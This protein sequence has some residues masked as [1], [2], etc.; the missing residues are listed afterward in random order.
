MKLHSPVTPLEPLD[1]PIKTNNL[2]KCIQILCQGSQVWVCN[3]I[4]GRDAQLY[5]FY[6]FGFNVL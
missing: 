4:C 6:G 5:I 2:K 1:T 3:E